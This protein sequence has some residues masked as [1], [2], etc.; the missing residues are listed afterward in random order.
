MQGHVHGGRVRRPAGVAVSCAGLGPAPG[1]TATWRDAASAIERAGRGQVLGPGWDGVLD[2]A[3]RVAL[4]G[5]PPQAPP[6]WS[7]AW[8]RHGGDQIGGVR[9][10]GAD[11][12]GLAGH[13]RCPGCDRVWAI[14]DAMGGGAGAKPSGSPTIRTPTAVFRVCCSRWSMTAAPQAR[15]PAASR[16][17]RWPTRSRIPPAPG[18]RLASARA[19]AR[20]LWRAD[21]GA[22]DAAP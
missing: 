15:D 7:G 8:W 13:V 19:A 1:S 9:A 10:V 20:V 11:T 21:G 14:A 22:V 5:V 16:R 6:G 17:R 4:A 18:R 12:R 2:T 3:R